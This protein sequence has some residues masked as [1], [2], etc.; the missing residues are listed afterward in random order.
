MPA[1]GHRAYLGVVKETTWGTAVLSGFNFGEFLSES[2]QRSIQE[3]P[4]PQINTSRSFKKWVQGR[5]NVAGNFRFAPNPDDL[6]GQVLQNGIWGQ[7]A[8]VQV[9]TLTVGATNNKLDFDIGAG[10]L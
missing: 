7:Q 1:L 3:I 5:V 2:V 9:A 6:L 4:V 10:A 8:I